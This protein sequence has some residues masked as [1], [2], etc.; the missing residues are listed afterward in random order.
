MHN[1]LEKP[2]TVVV[3]AKCNASTQG[4]IEKIK[5]DDAYKDVFRTYPEVKNDDFTDCLLVVVDTHKKSYLVEP[6]LLD[7][8]EK[9]GCNRSS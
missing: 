1:I 4:V 5:Y 8:F 3:D 7:H 9:S 6:D 2:V